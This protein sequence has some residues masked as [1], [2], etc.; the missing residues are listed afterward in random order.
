MATSPL[1]DLTSANVNP[2]Q[3]I[4]LYDGDDHKIYWVGV[5]SAGEEIECNSYLIVDG[6]AGYLLEP[7]G[8]DRFGPVFKKVCYLIS[9][10]AVSHMYFSHQDPDI[11]AS[12][13]S[14]IKWNENIQMIV[15]SL[16]TRFMPHYESR[17]ISGESYHLN[18]IPVGDEGATILLKSGGRLECISAPY[19]HSPGNILL[20]DT[21]SGFLFSGDVGASMFKDRAFHLLIDN[22]DSHTDAMRGFHQRYMSCNRAVA[23]MINTLRGRQITALLP[24]HGAIFRQAEVARYFAWLSHLPVGADY[25]YRDMLRIPTQAGH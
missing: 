12:F 23:G 11:C 4:L 20:F 22:W 17:D 13:P 8:F 24:Q 6:G 2:D 9:P 16:W 3:P 5:H 19:L 7:G 25:L 15:S 21:T 10:S 18:F 1:F 14:W